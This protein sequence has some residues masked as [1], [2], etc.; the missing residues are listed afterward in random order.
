MYY[1]NPC[2]RQFELDVRKI[3]H[4]DAFIDQGSIISHMPTLNVST[5]IEV[6]GEHFVNIIFDIFMVCPMREYIRF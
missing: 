3:I 1:L 2:I 4:L 6:M 5:R